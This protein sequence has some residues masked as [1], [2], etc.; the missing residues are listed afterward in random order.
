MYSYIEK[1]YTGDPNI[2]EVVGS[3]C[4]S[5]SASLHKSNPYFPQAQCK[6]KLGF[7]RRQSFHITQYHLMKKINEIKSHYQVSTN[8]HLLRKKGGI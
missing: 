4:E 2:K 1:I 5:R 8:R 7:V 3:F 6:K